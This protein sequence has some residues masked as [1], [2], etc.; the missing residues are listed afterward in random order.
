MMQKNDTLF[1]G[2][3]L[4][5]NVNRYN[6]GSGSVKELDLLLGS[7][8]EKARKNNLDTKVV[9]FIDEYFEKD[10][11]IINTISV[12][13]IDKIIYISTKHEPKTN[14]IDN[15]IL[16]LHDEKLNNPC[17]IVGIGGGITLDTAKAV[18]ILLTNGGKAS[19]Y[20]G[21]DLVK[22]PGIFKIGIPTISGTGAEATRTC[23]ITNEK[24]GLKLG[25][26]SDFTVF[27]HIIMDPDL[28]KTIPRD[29]YF[30]TGMDAYIHCIEALKGRYRNAIG[31]AL[32]RESIRLCR[33]V[34][35]SND[36]MSA[37][38]REKLM[39]ASYLGGCAIA[40]SYVGVI[41]PFSAGLS[42]VLGIHHC[43]GNCITMRA[44]QEFYPF[45]F[46]E[47]W[48]I[49]EKQNITIPKGFCK[50]LYIDGYKALYN[51]TIIHE[52]PLTNELGPGFKKFLTFEKVTELFKLM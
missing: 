43:Q 44:M 19:D 22:Q 36:M 10:K 45:E 23:V 24:S 39:V 48:G 30:Y 29:Q 46:D 50:D 11:Q 16:Q 7:V 33:E 9:F 18:S 2:I 35:N 17:A 51:S 32:S 41:H 27:D 37:I 49:V 14:Q 8:R 40:S 6:F 4:I 47:F 21:W 13:Y 34:F 15:L 42:V 12:N 31:D 20:Q 38:N 3:K 26:N 1:T 25:M 52:K 5:K 28:T